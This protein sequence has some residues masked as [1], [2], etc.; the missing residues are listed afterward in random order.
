MAI[1][2]K[3]R[4]DFVLM[5]NVNG[6]NRPSISMV[7]SGKWH[8]LCKRPKCHDLHGRPN[9]AAA[10]VSLDFEPLLLLLSPVLH[11]NIL[12]G[13]LLDLGVDKL[14]SRNC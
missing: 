14:H 6:L 8:D 7:C 13:L 12:A 4:T 9:T 5:H 10:V 1:E 11:P 3:C 2:R